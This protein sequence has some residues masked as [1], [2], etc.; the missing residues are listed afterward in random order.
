MS[1]SGLRESAFD[2]DKSGRL[3]LT[4][5]RM[6]FNN[7]SQKDAMKSFS[8]PFVAIRNVELEQP[9]F[10]ANYIKGKVLAQPNG[11]FEGEAKFKLRFK[12]GGAIDFGT[13]MLKAAQ[14]ASRNY[15]QDAP[16]PYTPPSGAWY[17]APPPAYTASPEG[18]GGWVPPTNVFPDQPPRKVFYAD[19]VEYLTRLLSEFKKATT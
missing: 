5:H 9:V 18:Y 2:G 3:Y 1:F 6:V 11:G 12:S 17:A 7:T 14:M 4:T 8:F 15:V 19:L 16:P 10:G 13:A